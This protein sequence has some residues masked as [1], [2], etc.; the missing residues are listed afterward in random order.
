MSLNLYLQSG[1][2]VTILTKLKKY[3]VKQLHSL[4]STFL[5]A[6]IAVGLIPILVFSGIV[7]DAMD[8]YFVEERKKELLSQANVISG[9]ITVSEYLYDENKYE[10]FE[11]DIEQTSIQ[12]NFRIIVT[13]A[14]GIVVADSN[15]TEVGK[16]YLIPEIV[17]ALDSNDVARMQANNI[18]YAAVS[19]RNMASSKVGAVLISA[20]ASDISET[21]DG[22]K[23]KVYMMTM[24]LLVAIVMVAMIISHRFTKPVGDMVSVIKR[25]SDGHLDQRVKYNEFSKNELAQL[26]RA[27]NNM[28]DKLEKVEE[29]R[30][31]F[32]SNVSHELK[33]PLSSIKVLSESI[34]LENN[35]P[36]EM[37]VEFLQDINSEVDRLT[38]IIND[39]LTLVKLDQKEIPLNFEEAE[40][41]GL[42]EEIVKRLTPM[43]DKKGVG[44]SLI[45]LKTVTAEFDRVKLTLALSNLIDNG[46]KYTPEGGEVKITVDADHQHAFITVADTGIGIAEEEI[47]KIFERFYRVD[48]T[49]D[50]ET[51]G[52]G[53]GLSITHSTVLMHNGSIRV[54][55]KENEGTTFFV[56]IPLRATV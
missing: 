23:Q 19:V 22:I 13:D 33:T 54:T 44:V 46:I 18:I 30:Q 5:I 35:V 39:L 56:R 4:K 32:V 26:A 34:L 21:I 31:T 49:R 29:T 20:D 9:H 36:K 41:N 17:E 10:D 16:I 43:A 25:G 12:G 28:A 51:G 52:T 2:W 53:L 3:I 40:L 1:E 42:L 24:V 11:Y 15:K 55:S 6:F 47:G 50:R 14:T 45:N 38:V 8:G 48:K 27:Y 37:Y 7:F